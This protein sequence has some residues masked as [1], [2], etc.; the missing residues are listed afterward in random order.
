M[1]RPTLIPDYVPVH[2]LSYY[3]MSWVYV[4]HLTHCDHLTIRAIWETCLK[5]L[6]ILLGFYS[7]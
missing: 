3:V 6:K 4:I 5:S 1:G 7:A 2:P